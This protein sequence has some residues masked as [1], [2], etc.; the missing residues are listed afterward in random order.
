MKH[1]KDNSKIMNVSFN[2]SLTVPV[3]G[4]GVTISTNKGGRFVI[5]IRYDSTKINFVWIKKTV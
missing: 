3:N 1:H 5:N 2:C 4:G